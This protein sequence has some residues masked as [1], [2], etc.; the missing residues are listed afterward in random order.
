MIMSGVAMADLIDF[1]NAG[2]YGG[3]NAAVSSKYYE[4]YGVKISAM[5]G[6]SAA[7]A[8]N[9]ILAFEQTGSDDPNRAFVSG[10]GV[11]DTAYSGDMGQYF[12]K[13]GTG[14][15]SYA[16]SKYFVMTIDYNEATTAASGEVWDIDGPEQYTVTAFDSNGNLVAS[17]VS[18]TGGLNAA[19]WTWSFDMGDKGDI[20]VIQV[21]A[22]GEGTL[23]G[24]AFDN[25]NANEASP[26]ADTHATPLPSAF[27]LG[28]FGLVGLVG[29]DRSRR[30]AAMEDT[31]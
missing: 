13:A 2:D 27:A 12:L 21:A 23:R 10:R 18:P 22:T 14:G 9:A 3:D 29:R 15:M 30:L 16:K 6:S 19:P 28:L 1:E 26:N 25:F 8:T 24:F 17:L 4:Q 20:D 31:A 11:D 5:A 7:D